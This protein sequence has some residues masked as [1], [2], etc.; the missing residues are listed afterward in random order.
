M[1]VVVQKTGSIIYRYLKMHKKVIKMPKLLQINVCSNMLSTGCIMED[2]SKVAIK[3]GWNCIV[4]FGRSSR[5]SVCQEMKI[6]NLFFTL[7]HYIENRLFDNEGL[8]SRIATLILIR[9]IKKE[10]PD[11]IHLHNIHDHYINYKI[12]FNYL[13]ATEIKV[14][15]TIHDFWPITGHCHHF[16]DANCNKWITQCHACPL[17]HSTVDSL[18]DR[19]KR[20]YLQKKTSFLSNRNMTLVPVSFWV[21]NMLKK[22]FLKDK[23]IIVIPNGIDV[24]SFPIE[25][26]KHPLL[27]NDKFIIL[28]VAREW[29]Y[30]DRKG[31]DEYL[32]ISKMLKDD[33]VIVLV[34]MSPSL[35]SKMPKNILGIPRTKT[36]E[37]L[38]S[39]YRFSNVLLSLSSAETFGLTIIEA[40]LCG[41]PAIVYN[42]TAPP[43]LITNNT[44]YVVE[45]KN[46][47]V[48][49]EKI[50]I[51]KTNG[52]SYYTK[53][54]VEHVL[55]NYDKDKNYEKYI[56][57]YNSLLQ[58]GKQN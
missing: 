50:Q 24:T 30:G 47:K 44:G 6:G 56:D 27:P 20:N 42:N 21:G 40:N 17:Q 16:I 3:H 45:N 18:L 15:W 38:A 11:I 35:A 53:A 31:L 25:V 1:K 48:L 8:A 41:I 26:P 28:G 2:I 57:L 32:K 34:G 12:L 19:S 37:E 9:K 23:N 49:Y 7:E 55:K 33:E 43:S 22:S 14:V 52:K 51:V 36:K 5:K 13:N 46:T 29:A 54:C 4:C 10:Q 39:I 58:K